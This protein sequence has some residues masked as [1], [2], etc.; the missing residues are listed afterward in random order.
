M[1]EAMKSGARAE[2]ANKWHSSLSDLSPTDSA[3]MKQVG[4]PALVNT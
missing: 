3:T 1:R 2:Q 4:C